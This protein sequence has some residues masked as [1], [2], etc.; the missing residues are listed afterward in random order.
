MTQ[1][2]RPALL[3]G[4]AGLIPFLYGALS[5]LV[6][7]TGALGRLWAETYHGVYLLQIYGIVILCFMAG[8]IW[9]FA[10]RAE[11]REATLFYV[12][13]VVPAIFVFLTAFAQPRPSLV[14]LI[15]G[16]VALLAV[17]GSATRQGL[18]PAWWM[19]L[20]LMLTA[21]VVVCL[22]IGVVA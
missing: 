22:G 20:R 5:V 17:D 6:P 7:A 12:L 19:S 18:A 16:F 3:L 1:I 9:G 4:L 14:M 8:V 21:V 11:G 10:A 2:P 13:S 15:V